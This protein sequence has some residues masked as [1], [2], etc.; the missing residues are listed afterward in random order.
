[1]FH[2][3]VDRKNVF[4]RYKN[5]KFKKSKNYN[6]FPKTFVHDFGAIF[7]F[8]YFRQHR[9]GKCVSQYSRMKKRLSTLKKTRSSRS[10]KIT[11]FPKRFVMVLVKNCDVFHP[12]I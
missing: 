3:I 2:D 10:R 5:K 12:F 8:F 9:P 4:L 6:F 1:M 11:I 7:P